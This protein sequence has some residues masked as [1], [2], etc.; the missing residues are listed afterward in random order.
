MLD[1]D[2]CETPRYYVGDEMHHE[3]HFVYSAKR[4]LV[5]DNF[6]KPQP[7]A[8]QPMFTLP[9][10]RTEPLAWPG[11]AMV[12]NEVTDR[13]DQPPYRGRY[14][15]LRTPEGYNLEL[16]IALP[17]ARMQAI[18]EGGHPIGFDLAVNDNDEG[19]GPLKQELHWSGMNDMFWRNCRFFGT[20]ILLNASAPEP[21]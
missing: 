1:N 14:A 12:K 7:G 5:F 8:P 21:K 11:E 13:F 20:L 3:F 17:G 18:D 16:R 2:G 10:G 19:S 4:P 9:D 15:F 6:W